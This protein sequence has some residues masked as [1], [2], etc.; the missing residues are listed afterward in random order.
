MARPAVTPSDSRSQDRRMQPNRA[1]AR[2]VPGQRSKFPNQ[3]SCADSRWLRPPPHHLISASSLIPRGRCP[4][5]HRE[6]QTKTPLGGHL[7]GV[8]RPERGREGHLSIEPTSAILP[9]RTAT[10]GSLRDSRNRKNCIRICRWATGG[11]L[12]CRVKGAWTEILGPQLSACAAGARTLCGSCGG[13]PG[14]GSVAAHREHPKA[15]R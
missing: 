8:L 7:S 13:C 4:L 3:P 6:G 9:S 5:V 10:V 14:P 12:R 11:H 15:D 2:F 1:A